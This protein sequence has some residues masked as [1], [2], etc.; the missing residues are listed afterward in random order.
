M[1]V[2]LLTAAVRADVPDAKDVDKTRKKV[3]DFFP[4]FVYDISRSPYEKNIFIYRYNHIMS[5]SVPF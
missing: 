1:S 4:V 3:F 2:R 5:Y